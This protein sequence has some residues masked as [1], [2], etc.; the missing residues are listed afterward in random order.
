MLQ[1]TMT[2]AQRQAKL[3][4]VL[5]P[6]WSSLVDGH[7][8][9]TVY[10]H[11]VTKDLVFDL[12]EVYKFTARLELANEVGQSDPGPT[13][14]VPVAAAASYANNNLS[15]ATVATPDPKVSGKRYSQEKSDAAKNAKKARSTVSLSTELSTDQSVPIPESVY[16]TPETVRNSNVNSSQ[17]TSSSVREELEQ[18]DLEERLSY[19][20]F[21]KKR[22][23]DLLLAEQTQRSLEIRPE[24][25]DPEQQEQQEDVQDS[26]GGEDGGGDEDVGGS[27]A[28]P[29][30]PKTND[31]M[32][33]QLP[34]P[35][36]SSSSSADSEDVEVIDVSDGEAESDDE[37]SDDEET[38]DS[39]GTS[40]DGCE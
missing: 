29:D 10:L 13:F 34:L 33:F 19:Q 8:G 40:K 3:Q 24:P 12:T 23:Y 6:G 4:P 32:K 5:P 36:S 11:T 9:K 21:K 16:V 38:D 26:G 30:L 37:E 31:F 22:E 35:N 18:A 2:Q 27:I 15:V 25:D 1:T 28:T 39:E 7:S 20:L 17:Y 14:G